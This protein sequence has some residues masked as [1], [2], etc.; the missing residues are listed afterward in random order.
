[1]RLA[2]LILLLSMT[3]PAAFG[4][5][6][7]YVDA[8]LGNNSNPGTAGSPFLTIQRAATA[9]VAGDLCIVKAGTYREQVTPTNNNVTFRAAAGET[10]V[11]SAF[12]HITGWTVHSNNIYRVDLAWDDLGDNNQVIYNQQM[13]NLARWPNKTNFNPFDIQAARSTSGTN[14]S[15]SQSGIPALNWANGGV[16]WYLGRN[17]WTSWRQPITGSAAGV[18]NFNTLPTGWE[19]SN[20]S[21][22]AGGEVILMNI[23]EALDSPG[24]WYVDRAANRVY[25]QTP[26]GE[27]PDAGTALVRRRTNVFN[28]NGRTGVRLYG[29]QI[30]GGNVDLRGANSCIVENC[31]IRFGNHTIAST[32]AAFVGQSSIT[33]NGSSLNNIIRKND[34]QWGASS[35]IGIG[36]TNNLITN[37]H[38]GNFNYLGTTTV[39]RFTFVATPS[40]SRAF[41]TIGSTTANRATITSSLTSPWASTWTTAPGR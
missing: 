35:G 28:L 33:L 30:E 27:D 6:T 4:G 14:S 25:L 17:R 40:I 32:S 20:H 18:V 38:I 29:L 12:E 5:T 22:T 24:E 2:L 16:V 13:M 8:T 36:G 9:M 39:V 11:V 10:V 41:T 26:N 23:L 3:A 1:M 37:N 31:R 7:Y 15:I 19:H 21:P 34:I